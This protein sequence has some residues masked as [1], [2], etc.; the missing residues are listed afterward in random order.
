MILEQFEDDLATICSYHYGIILRFFETFSV[1]NS[2]SQI[3]TGLNMEIAIDAFLL[4]LV[5]FLLFR[6]NPLQAPVWGLNQ[7]KAT[8]Q[9]SFGSSG[10]ELVGVSVCWNIPP[11]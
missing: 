5:S 6:S 3:S 1:E 8:L 4:Y 2:I 10:L 7:V 9:A 11:P